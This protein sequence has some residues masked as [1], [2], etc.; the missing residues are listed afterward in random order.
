MDY[1]LGHVYKDIMFPAENFRALCTGERGFGYKGSIFHRV[2]P[3]FMC[4]VSLS[5]F[6]R[7]V[8]LSGDLIRLDYNVVFCGCRVETSPITTELEEGPFMDTCFLM[9]TSS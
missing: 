3:E 8:L 6:L 9:R 2:I 7:N 1:S 4:Q 5:L